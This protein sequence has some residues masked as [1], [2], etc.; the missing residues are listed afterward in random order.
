MSGEREFR[1]WKHA[2]AIGEVPEGFA[3]RVMA[4]VAREADR[5]R[6][7]GRLLFLTRLLYG[8]PGR[9]AVTLLA[10]TI[11]LYRAA[12]AFGVFYTG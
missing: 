8:L 5:P 2:R 11:F 9:V 10:A 3:D 4:E 7:S 1:E 12:C 6:P